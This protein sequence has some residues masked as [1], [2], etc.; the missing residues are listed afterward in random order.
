MLRCP[1]CNACLLYA[2]EQHE[3]EPEPTQ[4]TPQEAARIRAVVRRRSAE[5]QAAM[6]KRAELEFEWR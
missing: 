5:E 2:S 3:C 6:L 4:P 1:R